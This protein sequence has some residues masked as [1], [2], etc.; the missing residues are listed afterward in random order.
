MSTGFSFLKNKMSVNFGLTL[1]L[2][3]LNENK[4]RINKYNIANGGG[5]F[6]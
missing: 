6:R 4:V 5:L 1:I 3:H 2:M